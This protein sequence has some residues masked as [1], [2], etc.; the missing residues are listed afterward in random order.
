MVIGYDGTLVNV[1][2]PELV[3]W[4]A[5]G[6]ANAHYLGVELVQSKAGDHISDDQLRTLAW[7]IEQMAKRYS[8]PIDEAHLLEHRQIPQG[9]AAAK[10]DIGADYSFGRMAALANW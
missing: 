10:S 3:A 9:I 2:D 4:H 5:G 7:W 8:F 1:V 6:Y